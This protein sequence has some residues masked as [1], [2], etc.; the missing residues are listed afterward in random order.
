MFRLDTSGFEM[1]LF[2][3]V[4]ASRYVALGLSEDTKMGED[5]VIVCGSVSY[6]DS[7]HRNIQTYFLCRP[8]RLSWSGTMTSPPRP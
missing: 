8:P 6:I 1:E 4:G 7:L 3:N 2:T 5:L